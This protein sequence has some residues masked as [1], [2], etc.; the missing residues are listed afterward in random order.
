MKPFNLVDAMKGH[1][2]VTRDGRSVKFVAY[3]PEADESEQVVVLIE[4]GIWCFHINGKY[5]GLFDPSQYDL[6]MASQK[7]TLWINIYRDAANVF[8]S[9][10]EADENASVTRLGGKAHLLQIEA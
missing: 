7:I 6:F 1:P 3:A 4:S 9:Q 5:N 10:Q 8:H 2:I